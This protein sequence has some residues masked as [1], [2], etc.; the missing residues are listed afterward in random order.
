MHEKGV[1]SLGPRG[2][3]MA[4]RQGLCQWN[5]RYDYQ[6]NEGGGSMTTVMELNHGEA[7]TFWSRHENMKDLRCMGFTRKGSTEVLVGGWQDT[8]FVID[9]IRGEVVREVSL[10]CLLLHLHGT[11]ADHHLRFQLNTTTRS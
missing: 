10:W 8:I 1:I 2:V 5:I 7:D 3:H 4:I 11:R 6:G 9:I